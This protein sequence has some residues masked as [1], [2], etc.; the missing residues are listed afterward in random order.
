MKCHLCGKECENNGR[1]Y[2]H[3]FAVHREQMFFCPRGAG[4]DSP[5]VE[6]MRGEAFWHDDKKC[7][8]CG[9]LS[10]DEFI[11]LAEAGEQI[12]PTDKNY[13]AYVGSW[14][15]HKFYYQH[16]SDEQMNRFIELANNGTMK[17]GYPGRF[18]VRP[19]FVEIAK[20]E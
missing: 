11:R 19:F 5:F 1:L 6:G 2:D 17:I 18:Y 7:S 3:M 15:R 12:I 16:L 14:Y 8:F 20:K 9:S 13:K 4:P 10:G